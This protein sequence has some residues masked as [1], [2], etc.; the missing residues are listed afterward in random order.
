MEGAFDLL[1]LADAF[2]ASARAPQALFWVGTGA[3]RNALYNESADA[4]GRLQRDYPDYRWD[5]VAY[6]LGRAQR[7]AG[8]ADAADQTWTALVNRA[9]DIYY[10]I[11]AAQSLRTVGVIRGLHAHVDAGD[12]RSR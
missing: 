5:A 8:N 2:P 4:F 7:E 10:G 1:A 6:W 11:L 3:F 9:P 12:R